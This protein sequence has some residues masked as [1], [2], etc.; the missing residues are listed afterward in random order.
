MAIVKTG[1]FTKQTIG[2][3]CNSLCHH[4]HGCLVGKA[5]CATATKVTL[6]PNE[7]G[8]RHMKIFLSLLPVQLT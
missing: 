1:H 7:L 2:L 3:F 6:V 5:I 4:L 8:L